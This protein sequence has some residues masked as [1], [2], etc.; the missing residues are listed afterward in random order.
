MS[1]YI[2]ISEYYNDLLHYGKGHL[3]GGH[4]GRYPWGSGENPYQRFKT[5]FEI[6]SKLISQDMTMKERMDYFGMTELEYKSYWLM[7]ERDKN[8]SWSE[9]KIADHYGLTM[10]Q[11][12]ETVG[13]AKQDQ[14]AYNIGWCQKLRDTGMSISAISK[15]TGFAD[16][17]V[18]NYLKPG[19]EEKARQIHEVSEALKIQLEKT[20]YIQVGVGVSNVLGVTQ[21]KLNKALYDL[22]TQGYTVTTIQIQQQASYGKEGHKTSIKV[23]GPPGSTYS[24]IKQNANQIGL[25]FDVHINNDTNKADVIQYPKSLNS[26]R[27]K[28]HYGDEVDDSGFTGSAKDGVIEL[29]RGVE[30]LSLGHSN[31]A[32]VRIMVDD[33]YY[34]KGMAMY[35]DNLPDGVDVLVNSNKKL[36]TPLEKVLKEIPGAA[37]GK[38]SDNPNAVFGATIKAGGQVHYIKDGKDTIGVINK[39]NEEGD[40]DEWSRTLASQMLSKQSVTLAKRQLN[41]DL[42]RQNLEFQ[43]ILELD[44]P[45]IKKQF[46]N[47]LAADC[48]AKA[49]NLKA[50]AMPG[51]RAQVILPL[52]Q[53]KDNEIYA[54]NYNN[55]DRVVLIRYPHG[56]TFEIPEL[57][58]NNSN[59]QGKSIIGNAMDA[60]GITPATA[61]KL[62]GADFD[63]DSVLVIPNPKGEI[64]TAKSLPG[65]VNFD[66]KSYKLPEDYP[67]EGKL[68]LKE[69]RKGLEMGI[70]S[71]L[72]TD[73]QLQGADDK[74]LERAVKYSMVVIDAPKHRLNYIQAANDLGIKQL[75]EK[76]QGK[77]K[78]GASTLISKSKSVEQ[79]SKRKAGG[80]I[81]D[82]DGN[83]ILNSLG[84]PKIFYSDPKTG[85]KLYRYSPEYYTQYNISIPPADGKGKPHTKWV[86]YKEW[87]EKYPDADLIDTRQKERLVNSTKMYE[88]KDAMT[89]SSGTKMEN[90]YADYANSM[91]SLGNQCRLEASRIPSTQQTNPE[92]KK[93]YAKEVKE[94]EEGIG[95]AQANEPLER[96]ANIMAKA[97]V[98]ARVKEMGLSGEDEMSQD[99]I[100]RLS[101]QELTRARNAIGAS[102]KGTKI[103]LTEDQWNAIQDGAV[104]TATQQKVIRY[105]DKDR[106]R[107]LATPKSQSRSVTTAEANLIR[108]MAASGNTQEEIAK[109]LGISVSTVN[110][111]LHSNTKKT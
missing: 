48:D 33:K 84:K 92:A 87:K 40:W 42:D 59:K 57:I 72:I 25:P 12:R 41:L 65:L 8:K 23:L 60:V 58:V 7:S 45:V 4:S 37:E 109:A 2:G 62:S 47:D 108:S 56:G 70:A 61:Q 22:Q 1:D 79:I 103:Q 81:Y 107:Q 36:G 105:A 21:T 69:S 98:E 18:R 13:I 55:G 106:L 50:A 99:K 90:T 20:P 77:P 27:I 19:A 34:I 86:G 74:E 71:N 110:S 83:P 9:K 14:L 104:S 94:L 30:D 101:A 88:A 43:K 91:K 38:I 111:Y 26:S 54:P 73:M 51:Q 93:K 96:Q 100:A 63:G 17:S 39:V 28:I 46:L 68:Y 95:K 67:D 10:N 15:E 85:E 64:K 31:Y 35:S 66:T 5:F 11:V 6:N 3:D 52:T 49:V 102:G 53:M 16:T 32:Q 97:A 44:N 89:L 78:G 75:H 82:E 29:R 80:Y 76:Y 24:E